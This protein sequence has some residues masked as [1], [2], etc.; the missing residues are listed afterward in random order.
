M[1]KLIHRSNETRKGIYDDDYAFFDD[2]TIEHHYDKHETDSNRID[3]VT[4]DKIPSDR[5]KS[6]VEKCPEDIKETIKK[7]LNVK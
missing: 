1:K 6:I 3:Q 5:I 4:A 2:G 7:M